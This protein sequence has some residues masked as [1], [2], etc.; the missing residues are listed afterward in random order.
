LHFTVRRIPERITRI[1]VPYE[2]P[3]MKPGEPLSRIADVPVAVGHG[4]PPAGR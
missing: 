4:S 2:S 1:I 3:I